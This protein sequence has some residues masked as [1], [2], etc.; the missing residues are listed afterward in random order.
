MLIYNIYVRNTYIKLPL[1][2]GSDV[3]QRVLFVKYLVTQIIF[4]MLK[5]T[6]NPARL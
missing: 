1:L 4:F 6:A 2:Q 5:I 3:H